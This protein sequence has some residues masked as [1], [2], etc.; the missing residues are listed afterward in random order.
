M[1]LTKQRTMTV[2]HCDLP[3]EVRR[4]GT[5]AGMGMLGI[6]MLLGSELSSCCDE[7][8][9]ESPSRLLRLPPLLPLWVIAGLSMAAAVP[10]GW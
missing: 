7:W 6:S 9:S 10:S 5:T 8:V 4:E 2:N 3:T 1:R